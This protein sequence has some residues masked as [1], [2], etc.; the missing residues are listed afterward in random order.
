MI[1]FEFFFD[2][3]FGDSGEKPVTK[4]GGGENTTV[5]LDKPPV[6]LCLREI[7]EKFRN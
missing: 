2:M 6:K 4:S 5:E 1:F 3:N 7:E